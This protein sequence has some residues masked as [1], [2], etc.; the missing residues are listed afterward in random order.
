MAKKVF[1][2][3]FHV[4][5]NTN[6]SVMDINTEYLTTVCSKSVPALHKY[7]AVCQSTNFTGD[8]F[9]AEPYDER[10]EEFNKRGINMF[11]IRNV[12]DFQKAFHLVDEYSTVKDICFSDMG[13]KQHGGDNKPCIPTMS[14]T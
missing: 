13:L 5:N 6:Y 4:N 10:H 14:Q 11:N 9:K 12:D 8:K 3:L 7:L 1:L 2:P